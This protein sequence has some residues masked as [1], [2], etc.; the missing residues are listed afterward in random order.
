MWTAF[1][2]LSG[3]PDLRTPDGW[4]RLDEGEVVVERRPGGGGLRLFF[5]E[6]DAVDYWEGE[7]PPS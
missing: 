6:G 4:R 7:R 1:A 5:R 2:L 3:T